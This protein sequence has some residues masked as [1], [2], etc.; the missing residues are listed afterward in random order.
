[1]FFISLQYLIFFVLVVCVFFALPHRFRW[2]FLLA[3]SYFYYMTW[4]PRYALLLVTTT[5]IVYVTAL[6]MQNR[7]AGTR[8]LL[9]VASLVANLSILFIFKYYNFFS[10]SLNDLFSLIGLNYS[11]PSVSLLMPVGISFYTFQA[12][13]YTIDVYRGTREPER[14]FGIFAL[15]VSFF[16]V[17]LSG[18]IER[19][20]TLLPQLYQKTEFNYERVT[21][22]LK[23][24]AWGFFQKLVIADRLLEY[25][26]M[27]Y[28][29]SSMV[30]GM[31]LVV[32]TYFYMF[33]VFCDF[34]GYTDIAIGTAQVMGYRLLPNFKRP[35][36]A[37]SIPE[38]WRRWHMSLIMWIRDYIYIPLG[39]SRVNRPRW[40]FNIILVFTLSGLWHGAQWTFVTWGLINGVIIAISRMT[41]D[42]RNW[43]RETI[44]G[45]IMK[46]TPAAYFS[47]SA[48][49]VAVAALGGAAGIA[50]IAGRAAAGV[51]GLAFLGIG[52][53]RTRERAYGTFVNGLKKFWM[54]F[55]MF[56][57]FA[58]SA[59]FFKA[60]SMAQGWYILSHFST[61]NIPHLF[62]VAKP[63]DF[64]ITI[65]L[66]VFL[67]TI[68]YIQ[69]TRGSIRQLVKTKP[70]LLRWAIYYLLVMSIIAGMR[71]SSG[72]EYFRF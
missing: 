65:F 22:G 28:A 58:V 71:Q 46:I 32:A 30:K 8:K 68:H 19:S 48:A 10:G 16:P 5:V 72:F 7:P 9:A 69:A 55:V 54:I 39:G 2:I 43:V 31:P 45:G 60:K 23:L 26:N 12:L 11:V 44:F 67:L 38:I 3:A 64:I 62:L 15:Y 70:L 4:D 63:M 25:A 24:M 57:L 59:V 6:L 20:T 52:V 56:Q 33:Q 35:F 51:G 17:I 49:C 37:E 27:V 50:G 18:P 41:R 13:G 66:I 61:S 47:L 40:A 29:N 36:F 42:M 53:L 21:D 1:M 34:S 14:N